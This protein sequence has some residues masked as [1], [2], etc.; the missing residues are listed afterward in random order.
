[1]LQEDRVDDGIADQRNEREQSGQRV[2][3]QR[4]N[5]H[6]RDPQEKREGE[7]LTRAQLASRQRT[8]PGTDHDRVEVGVQKMIQGGTGGSGHAYPHRA[9]QQH[10]ERDHTRR[11]EKHAYDGREH[12]QSNDSGLCQVVVLSRPCST[13]QRAI[14]AVRS[15]RRLHGQT[16]SSTRP[17]RVPSR[18]S[19]HTYRISRSTNL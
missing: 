18:R 13:A 6:G 15:G 17:R 12:D 7:C 11:R 3:P 10:V 19:A 5:R 2:H 8:P 16:V 9:Q 4:Q 1:M 14:G